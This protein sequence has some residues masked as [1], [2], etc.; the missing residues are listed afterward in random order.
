MIDSK[1]SILRILPDT[2]SKILY[3]RQLRHNQAV[4]IHNLVQMIQT[5]NNQLD[6]DMKMT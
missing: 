4:T 5:K 3:Q 1:V 2:L 6:H